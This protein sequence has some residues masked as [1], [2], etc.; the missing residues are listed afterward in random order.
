MQDYQKNENRARGGSIFFEQ[1][2]QQ[3]SGKYRYVEYQ[4]NREINLLSMN[5]IKEKSF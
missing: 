3:F 1:R 2:F 4:K 5:M